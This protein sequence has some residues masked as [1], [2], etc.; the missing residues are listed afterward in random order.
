MVTVAAAVKE[1]IDSGRSA[2]RPDWGSRG[3]HGENLNYRRVGCC[4]YIL[5]P[6]IQSLLSGANGQCNSM[7]EQ[8]LKA[9]PGQ[10]VVSLF[11]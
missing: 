8:R 1:N 11:A 7:Q 2:G 4:R 5:G 9:L 3:R 10:G 6:F